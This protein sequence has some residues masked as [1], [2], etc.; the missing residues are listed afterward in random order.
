LKNSELIKYN[1]KKIVVSNIT[2]GVHIRPSIDDAK[3]GG[4]IHNFIATRNQIKVYLVII[5]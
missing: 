2:I 3:H 1:F 4:L 5:Q